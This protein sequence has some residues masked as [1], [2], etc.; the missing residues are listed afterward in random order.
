MNA[1]SLIYEV[2]IHDPFFGADLYNYTLSIDGGKE[3]IYWESNHR[4]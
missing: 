1:N 3:L 2:P 4:K